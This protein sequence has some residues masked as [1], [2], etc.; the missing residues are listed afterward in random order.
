MTLSVIVIIWVVVGVAIGAAQAA[1]GETRAWC[2]TLFFLWP[3]MMVIG[4]LAITIRF[5]FELPG[6]I[7]FFVSGR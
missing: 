2:C 1:N 4:L 7:I 3:I 6:R 5:L